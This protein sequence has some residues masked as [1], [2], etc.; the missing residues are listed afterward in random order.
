MKI[1]E[2]PDMSKLPLWAK[3][4]NVREGWQMISDIGHAVGVTW[5]EQNKEYNR[6]HSNTRKWWIDRSEFQ[7]LYTLFQI[8]L[9]ELYNKKD[10]TGITY[11]KKD[12]Y[13]NGRFTYN[14]LPRN[15]TEQ[16]H[17]VLYMLERKSKNMTEEERQVLIPMLHESDKAKYVSS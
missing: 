6:W 16:Q 9:F 1:Y 14:K 12:V 11:F 3:R 17:E 8:S 10:K 13:F 5:P 2:I 4:V 7:R 15:R